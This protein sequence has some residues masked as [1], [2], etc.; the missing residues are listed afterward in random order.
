MRIGFLF[1]H[2]QIHQVAH[3]APVAAALARLRPDWRI[4]VAA[5][6][7]A[8]DAELDRL[9]GEP[10]ANLER[11]RLGHRSATARL[12]TA[13][14]DRWLPAGKV[15]VY[16]DNLA[17]F[18]SLDALVVAEKTSAIL[19]TRYGLTLPLIHTRH[20]AGDRAVG[21]DAASAGFDHVLVSGPKI[22]DRLLADAGIDR[23]RT[24]IV[25]YP[26]FD[27]LAADP[28]VLPLPP[29]R[30]TV[31]YNP[32]SSPALSSWFRDGP[33]VLDWFVAHPEWNLIFAPHVMLFE[34]PVT[35]SLSPLALDR[36]GR[37]RARWRAAPNI[38]IDLGSRASTDMTY[39]RAADLYLGD[40]S[41]QLYEFLLT[42][43]P[44][45]F[46][47]SH[48]V[49]WR[50]RSDWAHWRS[51]EVIGGVDSLGGA[52]ARAT[53]RHAEFRSEQEALFAASIELTDERSSD[54]AARAIVAALG[55][56]RQR[57]TMNGGNPPGS[58]TIQR[59]S[60]KPSP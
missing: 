19:R 4:V 14:L 10:P 23:A 27:T 42:P 38:L 47:N 54:R 9:L 24:S 22:R 26:K 31:L 30:P 46:L 7:D 44:A 37:M 56:W 49:D 25:G 40:V 50:G 55:G 45:V 33:A 15:T 3:A 39:T 57:A 43:R 18:R 12:A 53:E 51:G 36:P 20:G 2:D 6:T 52:L 13:A 58:P 5:T 1:N 41:S 48:G 60:R 8:L 21:F 16:R 32:H 35:L 11:V 28:P 17:F 29:G 59:R 34:R